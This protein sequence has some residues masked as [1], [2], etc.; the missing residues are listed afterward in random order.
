MPSDDA[1]REAAKGELGLLVLDRPAPRQLDRARE[2]HGD[3]A[4]VLL[5]RGAVLLRHADVRRIDLDLEEEV[6]LAD[7]AGCGKGAR[8][9]LAESVGRDRHPDLL[10]QLARGASA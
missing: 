7:D 10:V 8:A 2:I 5:E 9:K 3:D 4:G 1:L 6:P